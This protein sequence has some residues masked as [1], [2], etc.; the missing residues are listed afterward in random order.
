[1]RQCE[2]AELPGRGEA[3]GSERLTDAGLGVIRTMEVEVNPPRSVI[4]EQVVIQIPRIDAE[5]EHTGCHV[6][7]R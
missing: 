6:V 5:S 3:L 1:M 4:V 2:V 7:E